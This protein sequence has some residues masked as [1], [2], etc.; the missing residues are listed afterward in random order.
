[1]NKNFS[2][3]IKEI[4]EPDG[5]DVSFIE[6][7]DNLPVLLWD[8]E[9]LKS[10]VRKSLLLNVKRFIEFSNLENISFDDIILVGSTA[11]YN[12]NEN[13][14]ID[15][16]IVFDFKQIS[17]NIEFVI[18]FLKIKK[19]LWKENI[20]V[21]IKGYDLELYYQD[22]NEINHSTGVYS[23]IKNQWIRKPI[24]KI[25][26]IN[27]ENLKSKSTDFINAINDLETNLSKKNWLNKYTDLKN[28]IKKYRQTGLDKKGEFSTENL[29]FKLLRNNGHLEKLVNLKKK[30]LTNELTLKEFKTR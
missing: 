10:D 12:Y 18:E 8:G 13:S 9:K 1:M 11:N 22:K 29:V 21:K 7:H 2:D 30:Y 19:E 27:I 14:D 5:I 4:I 20:P 15:I 17:E 23:I 28:K 16:H 25:I 3:L 26:N 24:K 6:M